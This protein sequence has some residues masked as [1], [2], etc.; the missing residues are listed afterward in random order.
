MPYGRVPPEPRMMASKEQFPKVR[1]A[2]HVDSSL[3][4][5]VTLRTKITESWVSTKAYLKVPCSHD[6][7]EVLIYKR[8]RL[9]RVAY[10]TSRKAGGGD[11]LETRTFPTGS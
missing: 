5:S 2:A 3:T 10:Q 1:L 4:V 6:H 7:R 8:E 9:K 11:E